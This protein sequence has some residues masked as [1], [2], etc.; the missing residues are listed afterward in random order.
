MKNLLQGKTLHVIEGAS[1]INQNYLELLDLL[2]NT[3]GNQQ[4]VA[5]HMNELL[6]MKKKL[7]DK[8]P[9]GLRKFCGNVKIYFKNQPTF[10]N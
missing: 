9:T 5:A 8:D 7:T 1:F 10:S 3:Y 4:C 2:K 6:K